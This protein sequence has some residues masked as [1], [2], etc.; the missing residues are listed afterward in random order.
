MTKLDAGG[1]EGASAGSK[2]NVAVRVRPFNKRGELFKF[3][4][5]F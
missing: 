5:S 1:S 4:F 2:V 3:F